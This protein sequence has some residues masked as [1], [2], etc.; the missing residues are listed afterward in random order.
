[1]KLFDFEPIDFKTLTQI[2]VSK[3]GNKKEYEELHKGFQEDLV[4]HIQQDIQRH[5]HSKLLERCIED[6]KKTAVLR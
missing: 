6:C 5:V 4:D 3:N 2:S 1:M